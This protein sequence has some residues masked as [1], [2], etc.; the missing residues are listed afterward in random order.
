M[1]K[2]MLLS[3]IMYIGRKNGVHIVFGTC[4]LTQC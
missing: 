4:L 2:N 3:G 1:K